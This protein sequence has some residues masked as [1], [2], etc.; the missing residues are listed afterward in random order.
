MEGGGGGGGSCRGGRGED[1]NS[2]LVYSIPRP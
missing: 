1:R 2:A